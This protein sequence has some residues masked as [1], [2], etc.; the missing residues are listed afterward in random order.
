MKPYLSI[1]IP[2]FNRGEF[3]EKLLID[4]LKNDSAEEI[5]IVI[6]DNASTDKTD[7]VIEKYKERFTYFIYSKFEEN[8]GPDINFLKCV[9]LAT[10]EYC[11]LMGSDDSIRI[12]GINCV[13]ENI[14]KYKPTI[15][16]VNI[17]ECDYNLKKIGIHN[18]F[19]GDGNIKFDTKNKL[20]LIKLFESANPLWGLFFGYIS[21][22]V[23]RKTDWDTVEYN[24]EFNGTLFS[25]TS[26]LMEMIVKGCT[27]VSIN[28]AV[29]LNRGYNDS[30]VT[31]LKGNQYARLVLDIDI[32]IK[33]SETMP[34][35]ESKK[36]YIELARRNYSFYYIFKIILSAKNNEWQETKRKFLIIGINSKLIAIVEFLNE[37]QYIFNLML[38]LR[39]KFLPKRRII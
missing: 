7:E 22:I 14:E 4:I 38:K 39:V 25:F 28:E 1:C 2:T 12:D 17:T 3:L 32:Y 20:E 21:S 31:E 16:L 6:S 24:N 15:A 23:V 37:F 29:V 18:W 8:K 5:E 10:S 35:L 33:F 34:C 26:I 13:L 36:A 11:W 27:V 9:S 19:R 30:M